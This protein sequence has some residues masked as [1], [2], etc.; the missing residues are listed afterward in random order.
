MKGDDDFIISRKIL[1][2]RRVGSGYATY[3]PKHGHLL[4][5]KKFLSGER[6]VTSRKTAAKETTYWDCESSENCTPQIVCHF[7][8]QSH[9][10][11]I[12]ATFFRPRLKHSFFSFSSDMRLIHSYDYSYIAEKSVPY[13]FNWIDFTVIYRSSTRKKNLSLRC[14]IDTFLRFRRGLH[15]FQLLFP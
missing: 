5:K 2:M 9:S 6:C 14:I 15:I 12:R 8:N 4:G 11:F 1:R 10:F 3:S 7:V 13:F